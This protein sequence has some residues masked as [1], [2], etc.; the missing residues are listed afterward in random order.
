MAQGLVWESVCWRNGID[1][2]R[3]DIE[4]GGLFATLKGPNGREM[5]LP[6]VVWEGLLDAIKANRSTRT[7]GDQ[8]QQYPAR[9]RSR[10][11]EG[12]VTEVAGAYRS[13]RSISEIAHSHNRSAY[14]IEHQLDRLGLISKASMYGPG[15]PG[16]G[17]LDLSKAE[18][19]T[20][21]EVPVPAG[22]ASAMGEPPAL[23]NDRWEVRE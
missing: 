11:Y 16:A 7:R 19:K 9:A 12:E 13:G 21:G 1:Q 6:M 2:F 4:R 15:E 17:K 23:P 5:T 18:W 14:S 3:F 8:Q 20:P 10:W 22:S